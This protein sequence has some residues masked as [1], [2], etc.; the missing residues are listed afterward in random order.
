MT[1]GHSCAGENI[2][3]IH[4]AYMKPNFGWIDIDWKGKDT[5]ISLKIIS[6]E[7][8]EVKIEHLIPLKELQFK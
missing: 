2:N 7:E 8:G 1:H 6:S 4:G 3:R 5:Q